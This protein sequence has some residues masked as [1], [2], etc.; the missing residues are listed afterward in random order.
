MVTHPEKRPL[1]KLLP[2]CL[3]CLADVHEELRALCATLLQRG[4]LSRFPKLQAK[5]RDEVD[6]QLDRA[7]AHTQAKLEELIAMEEA[8]VYTDDA[9][10]LAELA[11]AVK[12]L[13]ARLDAPLLRAILQSYFAT[14]TRAV[15]N[16]APKAVML[17]MVR[18]TQHGLYGALFD[19]LSRCP[20]DGLLDEPEAIDVKRKAD[21]EL[22][23]KLRAAKR[24]LEGL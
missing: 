10:F 9:A 19:A 17:H 2:P 1:R 20:P 4:L 13:V 22:L 21:L 14:V 12:K 11:A 7:R 18:H 8:Y 3:Q 23:A 6:S 5:L 24:A 15:T 16:A